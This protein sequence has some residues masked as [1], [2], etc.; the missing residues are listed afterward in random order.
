V[1]SKNYVIDFILWSNNITQGIYHSYN[2]KCFH[3]GEYRILLARIS[4]NAQYIEILNTQESTR[5]FAVQCQNMHLRVFLCYPSAKP[6]TMVFN[7]Q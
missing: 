3:C 1:L 7:S 6:C 4:S 2:V 5:I